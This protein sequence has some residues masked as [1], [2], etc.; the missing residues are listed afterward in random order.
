[1]GLAEY[2][3][4]ENPLEAM[5]YDHQRRFHEKQSPYSVEEEVSKQSLALKTRWAFE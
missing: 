5:A 2:G 1:V 3:Y 4:R